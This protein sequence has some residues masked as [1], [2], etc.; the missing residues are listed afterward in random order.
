MERIES[1]YVALVKS[2]NAFER[3]LQLYKNPPEVAEN[4]AL[5][6]ALTAS[7]I[8]HFEL[9][10]ETFWKHLKLYLN[11]KFGVDV[12]G[13]KTI[14]RAIHDQRLI[15]ESELK[16]LLEIVEI[17]NATTHVYDEER[18]KKLSMSIIE[19]FPVMKKIVQ[20]VDPSR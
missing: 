9:F 19:H 16:Q 13:S 1:K 15:N 18:A 14:F 3:A 11:S 10:Y 20:A 4:Q 2:Q 5:Q 17:R 12:T 6:E 7:V 8:K